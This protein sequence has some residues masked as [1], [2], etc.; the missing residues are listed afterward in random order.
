MLLHMWNYY[1]TTPCHTF[2]PLICI[3]DGQTALNMYLFFNPILLPPQLNTLN[4]NVVCIPCHMHAVWTSIMYS[5]H[6]V[7]CCGHSPHLWACMKEL[8][9]NIIWHYYFAMSKLCISPHLHT[10]WSNSF[11]APS[12][13][14]PHGYPYKYNSLLPKQ[15]ASP[16]IH[17]HPI[18]ELSLPPVHVSFPTHFYTFLHVPPNS[19]TLSLAGITSQIYFLPLQKLYTPL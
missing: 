4:G 6:L 11:D 14:P 1:S 15:T 13:C 10:E 5:I 2:F 19:T 3:Q 12:L 8:S 18:P 7:W 16:L 9:I 17:A